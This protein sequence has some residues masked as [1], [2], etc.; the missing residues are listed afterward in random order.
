MLFSPSKLHNDR[1]M[2]LQ[3][4]YYLLPV[5][6]AVALLAFDYRALHLDFG[7]SA[8]VHRDLCLQCILRDPLS[9]ILLARR[10]CISREGR[11]WVETDELSRMKTVVIIPLFLPAVFANENSG[12]TVDPR[13]E[14]TIG[15]V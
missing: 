8:G 1:S 14:R 13:G 3:Y 9:P 12:P 6:V 2:Q 5:A 10:G 4:Y 15:W 11:R 7:F